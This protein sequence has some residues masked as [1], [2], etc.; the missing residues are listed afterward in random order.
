MRCPGFSCGAAA[1]LAAALVFA[2]PAQSGQVVV[3]LFTSQGCSA[4]PPADALLVE[5][6]AR[7]DVIAL[8]L[9]VD[10]WDY[11]GWRDSFAKPANTRRQR[12][13]VARLGGRTV[14]TPQIVVDGAASVVGSR[15]QAVIEE[16]ALAAAIPDRVAVRITRENDTLRVGVEP[17]DG[18]Q[19]PARVLFFVV[20]HPKTVSITRGENVGRRLTYHNVVRDWMTLGW[21]TGGRAELRAPRPE[22]ARSVAVVLQR[23]DGAILG[24]SSYDFDSAPI[25]AAPALPAEDGAADTAR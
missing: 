25:S 16:I 17:E 21:W 6:A 13:Y 14:F 4:C 3:E 10:Y 18:V 2:A 23:E 22:D 19:G 11:L 5:L 7:P 1:G 8:G 9:H 20:E 12:D 24:A 15:R